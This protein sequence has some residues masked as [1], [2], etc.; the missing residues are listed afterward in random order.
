MT[1]Y[2][3]TCK[4]DVRYHK[5]LRLSYDMIMSHSF[6]VIFDRAYIATDR[7]GWSA[8]FPANEDPTSCTCCV[9]PT[10]FL[11]TTKITSPWSRRSWSCSSNRTVRKGIS[12][13]GKHFLYLFLYCL[14]HRHNRSQFFHLH[15]TQVP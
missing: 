4:N 3:I 12:S 2:E 13:N 8:V 5:C 11:V 15:F 7:A 6:T 1:N 10:A 9:G 14:W